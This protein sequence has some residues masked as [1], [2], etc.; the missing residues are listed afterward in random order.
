MCTVTYGVNSAPFLAIRCLHQLNKEEGPS[1]PLA[2]NILTTSTHVD[3]IIAGAITKEDVL[4][5]KVE[6]V[7][8]LKL[9]KFNL[10]KWASNCAAVLDGIDVDDRAFDPALDIKD[11]H[12]I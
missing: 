4:R 7:E 1:F 6:I 3:D 12:S 10:K 5:L 8:L 11:D 9:G 2:Y